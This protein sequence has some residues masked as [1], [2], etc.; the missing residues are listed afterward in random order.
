M[1]KNLKIISILFVFLLLISSISLA[2]DINM[3]LQTNP[4]DSSVSNESLDT[5]NEENV[6]NDVT[7][8]KVATNYGSTMVT[9]TSSVQDES[10]GFTNILN[11][12]LIV[13]G[14]VLILLGVAILI[15]MHA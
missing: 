6:I 8:N 3:N 11:I 10:L 5:E 4:T 14:F 12:L 15:R 1:L 9:S 7:E 13:V 2:T